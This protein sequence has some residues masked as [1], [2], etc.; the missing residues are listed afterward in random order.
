[1]GK[2]SRGTRVSAPDP[3][4]LMQLQEQYNRV[5]T[6]GPFGSQR[7]STG[8]DG[9]T[10]FTTELSPQ[11]QGLVDRGMGL[12]GRDQQRYTAPQ[13]MSQLIEALMGRMNRRTGG[14]Q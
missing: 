8:A 3:R 4:Q 6:S 7:Y 1:M 10:E 12:A 14:G 11:L 2:S 5:N 13:G 9:R